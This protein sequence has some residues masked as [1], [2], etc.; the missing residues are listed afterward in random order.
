VSRAEA[1][2]F[3]RLGEWAAVLHLRCR[4]FR[5]LARGYRV[6]GGEIDIIAQRGRL[7]VFI[8]VKSRPTL[9]EASM[10]IHP[11]QGRRIARAATVWLAAHP[12]LAADCS[13]R[14]D[15]IFV[16]PWRWPRHL[17]GS[18]ELSGL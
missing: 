14:G 4:G 1:R 11:A 7:I 2:R 13:V 6:R 9:A 3:G 12:R 8:E 16:A 5:I 17:R 15:A 10:A 18:F